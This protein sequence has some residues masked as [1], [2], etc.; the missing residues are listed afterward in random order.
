MLFFSSSPWGSGVLMILV[1]V[2]AQMLTR[3]QLRG[4]VLI[5]NYWAEEGATSRLTKDASRSQCVEA[6]PEASVLWWLWAAGCLGLYGDSYLKASKAKS[7]GDQ[8]SW[9]QGLQLHV[10]QPHSAMHVIAWILSCWLEGQH[11]SC[12]HRGKRAT[13][14]HHYEKAGCT[15]TTSLTACNTYQF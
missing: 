8:G 9:I 2:S 11:R 13:P 3:M 10:T 14:R 4:W 12:P 1:G 7:D 15:Q 5:S 6:G